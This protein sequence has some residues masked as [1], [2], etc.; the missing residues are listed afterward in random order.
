[1]LRQAHAHRGRV[2]VSGVQFGLPQA[3]DH[4]GADGARAAAQ[5]NDDRPRPGR[6]LARLAGLAGEGDGLADEELGAAARDEDAGV[7]G[8]PQAAELGPADDVLERQAGRPAGPPWRPVQPAC[9]P[10]R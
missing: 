1:M 10:R 2:D 8:D 3:R 5:V 6:G 7:D 9:G 4:R